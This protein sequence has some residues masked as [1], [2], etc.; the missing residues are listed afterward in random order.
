MDKDDINK[1]SYVCF[2]PFSLNNSQ[3]DYFSQNVKWNSDFPFQNSVL[4]IFG[5]FVAKNTANAPLFLKY[6][7]NV[8]LHS[9]ALSRRKSI[10]SSSSNFL[11]MCNHLPGLV[12]V[13]YQNVTDNSPFVTKENNK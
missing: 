3:I 6:A 4:F 7:F 10:L 5:K 9:R 11:Q 13:L 2:K 1:I 12:Y 8:F